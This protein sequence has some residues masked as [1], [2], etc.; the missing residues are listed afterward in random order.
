MTPGTTTFENNDAGIIDAKSNNA[1]HSN[2][3]NAAAENYDRRN[4]DPGN[5]DGTIFFGVTWTGLIQQP[6]GDGRI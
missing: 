5:H 6:A 2:S 3:R 1:G 4:G